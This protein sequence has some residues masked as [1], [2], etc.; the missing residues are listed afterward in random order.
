MLWDMFTSLLL[1]FAS[2]LPVEFWWIIAAGAWVFWRSLP[3]V[4]TL[5]PGLYVALGILVY[6]YA[7]DIYG[8]GWHDREVK[9]EKELQKKIKKEKPGWVTK[10]PGEKI[11]E[12]VAPPKQRDIR[13]R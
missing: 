8:K 3:V 6:G 12:Y 11:Q 1:G 2:L 10:S 9:Y 13:R 7:G 5:V 4:G